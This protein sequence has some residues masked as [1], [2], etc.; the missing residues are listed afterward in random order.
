MPPQWNDTVAG[1]RDRQRQRIVDT[2]MALVSEHGLSDVTM[3]QVAKQAG[4]GRATLYKY[5]PGVEEIV[6][7]HVLQTVRSHHS[8]LE[9][10]IAG[11]DEPV[12]ALRACL[13]ILLEYFGSEG[14][15]SA[16]T[17][18]NPEQ[19]SPEV[20]RDVREAFAR[21]HGLLTELVVDAQDAGRLRD[22]VDAHFTAQLLYQ[23][24]AAGRAAVVAGRMAADDAVDR[25]MEQFLHGAAAP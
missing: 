1:H 19:F 17:S 9:Q 12:D 18:V 6:A 3:A 5:F 7:E 20:G 25:I 22:D 15:R 10:A 8:V 23:M 14:H 4:I 21:M 11:V 13:T 24:L 16:S 2:T